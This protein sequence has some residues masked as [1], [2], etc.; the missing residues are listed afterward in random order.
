[1]PKHLEKFTQLSTQDKMF[2]NV[3]C[4]V[5]F[6]TAVLYHITQ[7]NDF[8]ILKLLQILKAETWVVI[9]S[10]GSLI[11]NAKENNSTFGT[12]L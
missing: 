12:C 10:S 1:M 5:Y 8:N 9:C 3:F 7:S 4:G 2:N 11:G 6:V